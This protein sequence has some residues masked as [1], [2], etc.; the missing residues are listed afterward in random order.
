MG[1]SH[2]T[3]ACGCI[4]PDPNPPSR[5]VRG[6]LWPPPMGP[7]HVG[8]PQARGRCNVASLRLETQGWESAP[9][10][11]RDNTGNR[12]LKVPSH[13]R[14]NAFGQRKCLAFSPGA[15]PTHF[16]ES[17]GACQCG[18]DQ[19]EDVKASSQ[20]INT[21]ATSVCSHECNIKVMNAK[22]TVINTKPR[23][24]GATPGISSVKEQRLQSSLKLHPK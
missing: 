17:G 20:D 9:V 15:K 10:M 21:T 4:R 3:H 22:A 16:P 11:S 5:M 24:H 12:Q 8:M 18:T 6:G 2:G 13:S 14:H 19:R 1:G 7:H 23:C